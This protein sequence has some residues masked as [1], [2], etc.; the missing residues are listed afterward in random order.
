MGPRMH[1]LESLDETTRTAS[2][3]SGESFAPIEHWAYQVDNPLR[4]V[5]EI[6]EAAEAGFSEVSPEAR[7]EAPM[8]S[9]DE[10]MYG[11]RYARHGASLAAVH[12]METEG[13]LEDLEET[14]E[15]D[16]EAEEA[17]ERLDESD[18]NRLTF[19]EEDLEEGEFDAEAEEFEEEDLEEFEEEDLEEEEFEAEG[20]EFEEEDLEEEGLV[21]RSRSGRAVRRRRAGRPR[22]RRITL[23][24]G[25][26]LVVR[27]R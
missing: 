13:E 2:E 11:E 3:E 15:E 9:E 5:H 27:W 22:R 7:S 20:E 10:A 14:E 4:P 8:A 25:D 26:I 1:G 21:R 23:R 18:V 6:L 17:L 16:L 24:R 19:E 12:G